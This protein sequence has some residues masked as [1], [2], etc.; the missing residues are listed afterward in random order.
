ML[1]PAGH[2]LKCAVAAIAS[3]GDD[4]AAMEGSSQQ[5]LAAAL[6]LLLQRERSGTDGVRAQFTQL[7]AVLAPLAD[8]ESDDV[9]VQ[10][11]W[12]R[13]VSCA[14]QARQQQD[15][16]ALEALWRQALDSA[17]KLVRDC[18]L[19]TDGALGR[20]RIAALTAWESA[21]LCAELAAEDPAAAGSPTALTQ[22]SLQ[23]YL[24]NRFDDP[25]LRVTAFRPLAGG[26]GKL[27]YLFD[28]SAR[29][30]DGGYVMRRDLDDP[31]FDNDCHRIAKEYALIRA[32]HALGFPAPEALWLDCEHRDRKSTRL[33]SSHNPA[34]RM[35]SSA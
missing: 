33:N 21:Q 20:S 34:S 4:S 8:G 12:Q 3:S 11:A 17:E 13:L 22:D 9:A 35:P 25:Q 19:A 31:T 24:R 30:L 6:G 18:R 16:P 27:T 29:E 10:A 28:V 32:V 2:L 14:N 23:A 7:L 15:L 1:L 26:F 5:A